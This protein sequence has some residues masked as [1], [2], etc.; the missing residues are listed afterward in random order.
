MIANAEWIWKSS[1]AY[2]HNQLAFPN[3]VL[4]CDDKIKSNV[5]YDDTWASDG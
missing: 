3:V 1:P 5:G 4:G 2:K